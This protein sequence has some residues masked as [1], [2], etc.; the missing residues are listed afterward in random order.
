MVRQDSESFDYQVEALKELKELGVEDIQ[1]HSVVALIRGAK[2]RREALKQLDE[3]SGLFE[4]ALTSDDELE[5]ARAHELAEGAQVSLEHIS[6]PA[7]EDFEHLWSG[8]RI[9]IARAEGLLHAMGVWWWQRFARQV[10][11]FYTNLHAP[12]GGQSL[13]ALEEARRVLAQ[14]PEKLGLGWKDA[15][16][17]LKEMEKRLRS[18]HEERLDALVQEAA[19]WIGRAKAAVGDGDEASSDGQGPPRGDR[20]SEPFVALHCLSQAESPLRRAERLLDTARQEEEVDVGGAEKAPGEP[21]ATSGAEIGGEDSHPEEQSSAEPAETTTLEAQIAQLRA[22][23][24]ALEKECLQHEAGKWLVK[25]KEEQVGDLDKKLSLQLS[26][27]GTGWKELLKEQSPEGRDFRRDLDKLAGYLQQ[28]PSDSLSSEVRDALDRRLEGRYRSRLLYAR[29]AA[30]RQPGA[31]DV[32]ASFA[33]GA[34]SQLQLAATSD[35]DHQEVRE[36]L[37][38]VG[39]QWGKLDD[40]AKV[41]LREAEDRLDRVEKSLA[42]LDQHSRPEGSDGSTGDP[43]VLLDSVQSAMAEVEDEAMA[44]Y[45]QYIGYVQQMLHGQEEQPPDWSRTVDDLETMASQLDGRAGLVSEFVQETINTLST[46]QSPGDDLMPALHRTRRILAASGIPGG[47][48]R[49]AACAL[50][51]ALKEALPPPKERLRMVPEQSREILKLWKELQEAC[52]GSAGSPTS[53]AGTGGGKYG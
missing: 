16:E 53:V 45:N 41:A 24:E 28:I 38:R 1:G 40:R 32:P 42:G 37:Q 31:Q 50:R 51:H 36:L 34:Y 43:F 27:R 20:R 35:P 46:W 22:E 8:L 6:Y 19:L 17:T 5:I 52:E 25:E 7:G 21:P 29:V 48:R 33:Y 23:K 44:E 4:I 47:V 18:A 11:R 39:A 49:S 9:D 15:K 26:G 30:R 3:A 12:E 10:D 2:A 14:W 13:A